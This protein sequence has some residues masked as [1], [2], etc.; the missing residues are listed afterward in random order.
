MR[1]DDVNSLLLKKV[2]SL[3]GGAVGDERTEKNSFDS[4]YL[5]IFEI[6]ILATTTMSKTS[7]VRQQQEK[8]LANVIDKEQ[9][10]EKK[11]EKIHLGETP[12]LKRALDDAAMEV[13]SQTDVFF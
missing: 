4:L 5:I 11:V 10:P 1:R 9:Q 7:S 8:Q 2:V 13:I 6:T 12:A 3:E